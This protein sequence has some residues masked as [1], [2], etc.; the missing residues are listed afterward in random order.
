MRKTVNETAEYKATFY[1][2]KKCEPRHFGKT[3][4][5]HKD[6]RFTVHADKNKAGNVIGIEVTQFKRLR[7]R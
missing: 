3:M 2:I 7:R 5:I 6:K 4:L 1:E